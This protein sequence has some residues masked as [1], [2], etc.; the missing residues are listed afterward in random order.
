MAIKCH[1]FFLSNLPPFGENLSLYQFLIT[2]TLRPK[3]Q[4]QRLCLSPE[5]HR[6]HE[7]LQV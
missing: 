6:L 7:N 4:T 5:W 3:R 1:G 2:Q